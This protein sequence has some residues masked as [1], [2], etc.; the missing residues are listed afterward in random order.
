[1]TAAIQSR[2]MGVEKQIAAWHSAAVVEAN[3]AWSSETEEYYTHGKS[4]IPFMLMGVTVA[5]AIVVYFIDKGL[6]RKV[7]MVTEAMRDQK[8][9]ERLGEPG[10]EMKILDVTITKQSD[11]P[12]ERGKAM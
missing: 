12:C 1:M 9:A 11:E 10:T 3:E 5:I 6:E 2:T 8:A 7:R 4:K